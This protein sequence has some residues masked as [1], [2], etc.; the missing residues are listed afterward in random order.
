MFEFAI[1]I[2]QFAIPSFEDRDLIHQNFLEDLIP[3]P[4]TFRVRLYTA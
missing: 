2:F 4:A 3:K 1:C